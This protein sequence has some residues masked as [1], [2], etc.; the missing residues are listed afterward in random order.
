MAVYNP[1]THSLYLIE[2]FMRTIFDHVIYH[3]DANNLFSS[4]GTI[5]MKKYSI[6]TYPCNLANKV[7]MFRNIIK[8]KLKFDVPIELIMIIFT[9]SH[10][11]IQSDV[12][13]RTQYIDAINKLK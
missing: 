13:T 10:D 4:K 11:Y 2:Y 12:F 9:F 7:V 1:I 6:G 5:Q 3:V 8:T